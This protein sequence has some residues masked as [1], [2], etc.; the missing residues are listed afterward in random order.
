MEAAFEVI[1]QSFIDNLISWM[2]TGFYLEKHILLK[3]LNLRKTLFRLIILNK[4]KHLP[5]SHSPFLP[6][7]FS[8]FAESTLR[9]DLPLISAL[10]QPFLLP[11]DEAMP[12]DYKLPS[13]FLYPSFFEVSLMPPRISPVYIIPSLWY[14]GNCSN[15]AL[16]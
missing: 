1:P 6:F 11:L 14:V 13:L 2:G 10:R 5:L 15:L 4:S 16:I 3:R 7:I 9:F 8:R 12:H